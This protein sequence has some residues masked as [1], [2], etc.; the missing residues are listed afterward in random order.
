M[1]VCFFK[2]V[3]R[4]HLTNLT[5]NF[6]MTCCHFYIATNA[7]RFT[8]CHFVNKCYHATNA[9]NPHLLC[10]YKTFIFHYVLC[11]QNR[12]RDPIGSATETHIRQCCQMVTQTMHFF[13]I[14][15]LVASVHKL[16]QLQNPAFAP[17]FFFAC[18][19]SVACNTNYNLLHFYNKQPVEN[20]L[21]QP[22][23]T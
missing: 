9:T 18:N 17:L 14:P 5:Y 11:T 4:K 16:Y 21:S 22:L 7:I 12:G 23:G 1:Y 15:Y 13:F 20:D 3:F 6:R 8:G 10:I 19:Y 2:K